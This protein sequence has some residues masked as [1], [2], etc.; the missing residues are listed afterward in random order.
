MPT[1]D[2]FFFERY[3]LVARDL[4]RYLA[5][6]EKAVVLLPIGLGYPGHGAALAGMPSR[7][8]GGLS[9]VT[10]GNSQVLKLPAAVCAATLE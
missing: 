4:E 10:P 2:Q 8:K 7:V 9:W 3:G 6:A 5:A 1:P